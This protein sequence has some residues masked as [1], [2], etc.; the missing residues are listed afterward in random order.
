MAACCECHIDMS[1]ILMTT[2]LKM[3]ISTPC[4][5]LLPE[6]IFSNSTFLIAVSNKQF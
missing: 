3:A 6:S 2:Q 1:L 4:L 5:F